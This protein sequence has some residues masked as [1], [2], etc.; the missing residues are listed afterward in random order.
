M[1]PAEDY[2]PLLKRSH[3][4][5]GLT[6]AQ[7]LDV[8]ARLKPEHRAAKEVIFEQEERGD[9]FYL[10]ERGSVKVVLKEGKTLHT[11]ATY[12]PGDH[13]GLAAI[14]E[15]T[16]RSATVVTESE[17]DLLCLSKAS[18]AAL[19]KVYPQIRPNLQADLQTQKL[20]RQLKFSWLMPSEVIYLIA[21]RHP[22]LLAQSLVLPGLLLVL[23][24]IAGGALY[25]VTGLLVVAVAAVVVGALGV[26][27]WV[28]WKWVDWGNDFYIVTNLRV[29]YLEKVVGLYDSRQES[30][31]TS[32]LSVHVQSSDALSR[33]LN[34]GDVLVRTY[35]GPITMDSVHRPY[36]VA[37]LLE[38]HWQRAKEGARQAEQAAIRDA[39]RRTLH[40]P[41]PPAPA[42]SP[43]SA[44]SVRPKQQS[45]GERLARLFSLK[46]R[47]E[48]G[49][50]IIYRKHWFLLVR[51]IWSSSLLM[52]LTFLALLLVGFGSSLSSDYKLWV[53]ALGVAAIVGL[54]AW[55]LYEFIDWANDI[56]QI[57]TDQIVDIIR[58]PLG[59]EVR[60]A[61]PLANVL[62][63]R[64]ERIG[65]LGLLFNYGTVIADIGTAE[66]KFAGVFDPR[67]V[68]NDIYRR[69]EAFNARKAQAESDK[70][71]AEMT[72]WLGAY[73]AVA[74]EMPEKNPPV[75]PA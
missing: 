60:K 17:A 18:F 64:Y 46:V 3:L 70:R 14:L 67:G 31:L 40:P 10:I 25:L 19:L 56:Y 35:S 24:L 13:F 41:P 63:L 16:P 48:E 61:A 9:H 5:F 39:V 33:A 65:L 27:A 69:M 1:M 7:I 43:P 55:W 58:K 21:R 73:H 53:V 59:R 57:A 47:F 66:F 12:G 30:P 28:W 22:V 15:G 75:P 23:V 34:M 38:G 26:G 8:A 36:A 68:Q 11:L 42:P 72:Q 50:Y 44:P 51:D 32:I 37:A 20:A 74:S 45:L 71:R 54:A 62:S 6:D 52:V 29:V 49:D 2:V 4:F